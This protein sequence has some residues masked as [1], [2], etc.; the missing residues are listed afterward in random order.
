MRRSK[1]GRRRRGKV[2][3][4]PK[5]VGGSLVV[6]EKK[7]KKGKGKQY[8]LSGKK[9]GAVHIVINNSNSSPGVGRPMPADTRRVMPRLEPVRPILV[10]PPPQPAIRP[11]S[12]EL[13]KI[14]DQRAKLDEDR[15]SMQFALSHLMPPRDD[16]YSVYS[17]ATRATAPRFRK[18]EHNPFTDPA[19]SLITEA[20]E[21]SSAHGG[22]KPVSMGGPP[23]D[24]SIAPPKAMPA[25]EQA[26]I[27]TTNASTYHIVLQEAKELK[28]YKKM[29]GKRGE[30]QLKR[31][32]IK[33]RTRRLKHP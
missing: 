26:I 7:P 10:E 21:E 22:G 33:E 2:T 16:G 31:A 3:L 25:Q 17:K 18:D 4:H 29:R 14:D 8:K 6:T 11:Q 27:D 15:R 5:R 13:K 30:A 24:E 32:V 1:K 9:S 12:E 20:S 23:K 19:M 28:I